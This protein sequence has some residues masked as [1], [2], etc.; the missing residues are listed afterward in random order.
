MLMQ[1]IPECCKM[2]WQQCMVHQIVWY[3]KLL[4]TTI[5]PHLGSA[6]PSQRLIEPLLNKGLLYSRAS[7]LGHI[8]LARPR[9]LEYFIILEDSNILD[10]R[11]EI[12]GKYGFL[13]SRTAHWNRWRPSLYHRVSIWKPGSESQWSCSVSRKISECLFSLY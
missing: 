12:P 11:N 10:K 5:A 2:I 9:V 13:C 4:T 8:V 1:G 7:F 3:T 6:A